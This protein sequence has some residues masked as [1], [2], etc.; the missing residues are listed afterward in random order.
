M[1][2]RPRDGPTSAYPT[3]RSPASICRTG[4]NDVLLGSEGEL[5]PVEPIALPLARTGIRLSSAAPPAIPMARNARRRDTVFV[6]ACFTV[7]LLLRSFTGVATCSPWRESLSERPRCSTKM[8]SGCVTAQRE[9]EAV[10]RT[11][12]ALPAAERP[13][14]E[15]S[16]ADRC[17]ARGRAENRQ[18]REE[19]SQ[20]A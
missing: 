1:T 7:D 17:R 18:Y 5:A 15:W 9:V 4:G 6:F 2:V 16:G 11:T 20:S 10:A 8:A 3:F 12:P 14:T 13:V 19:L